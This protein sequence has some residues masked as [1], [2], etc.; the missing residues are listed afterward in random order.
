MEKEIWKDIKGYEGIYLVSNKGNIMSIKTNKILKPWING[1]Y[2]MVELFKNKYKKRIYIHRIVATTFLKG[3]DEYPM[4]LHSDDNPLNNKVEN[5]E[6]GTQSKNMKD[7][8][9]RGR[10]INYFLGKFGKEHCTS[11]R[12][13]QYNLNGEYINTYESLL[14]AEKNTGFHNSNISRCASGKQK[15]SNGFIFKYVEK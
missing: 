12:V 6:W 14:E 11:K 8:Y 15:T 9:N 13:S 2:Y 4:V 5:L 1:Q 3:F 7:A 10:K